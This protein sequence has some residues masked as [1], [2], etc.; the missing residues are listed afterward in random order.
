M[1][2]AAIVMIDKNMKKII[3][4]IFFWTLASNPIVARLSQNNV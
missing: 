1:G 2:F 4:K 3:Q